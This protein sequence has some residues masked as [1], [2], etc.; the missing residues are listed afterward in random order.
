MNEQ[1]L[2]GIQSA[3]LI[4]ADVRDSLL[5]DPAIVDR[6]DRLQNELDDIYETMEHS[7]V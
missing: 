2:W 7:A 4:L 6:L 5:N 1:T 3:Q